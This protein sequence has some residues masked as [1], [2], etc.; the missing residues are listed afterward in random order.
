MIKRLIKENEEQNLARL[1]IVAPLASFG[2]WIP[3]VLVL[4]PLQYFL[5]ESACELLLLVLFL[6]WLVYVAA[7][8]LR[9]VKV[10]RLAKVREVSPGVFHLLQVASLV[11]AGANLIVRGAD[12]RFLLQWM[13]C[14]DVALVTFYLS[15]LL[16]AWLSWTKIPWHAIGGFGIVVLSIFIATFHNPFAH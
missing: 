4:A 1:A 5:P 11:L 14:M 16:L 12:W 8:W 7:I 3:G 10:I 13:V 6:V 2:F 9:A 15:Y